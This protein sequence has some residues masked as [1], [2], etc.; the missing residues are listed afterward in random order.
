MRIRH[1]EQS[2]TQK[3][4]VLRVR[5]QLRL[6]DILVGKGWEGLDG[7]PRSH[8]RH[9]DGLREKEAHSNGESLFPRCKST[10]KTSEG[11]GQTG[12][13]LVR[14]KSCCSELTKRPS[15]S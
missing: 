5:V 1:A 3:T 4:T 6:Q 15:R 12:N 14:R 9:R 13:G 11:S 2:D 7:Q 8:P 10:K